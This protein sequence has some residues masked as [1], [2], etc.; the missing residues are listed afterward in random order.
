LKKPKLPADSAE[1]PLSLLKAPWL[2][3]YRY[4]GQ[5]V[6]RSLPYFQDLG[7]TMQRAALKISLQS[8][9]SMMLLLSGM[10][11]IVSFGII[12]SVLLII[13]VGV[14][15][16]VM[17]SFG[18]GLLLGV[19]V[20]SLLYFLP[21][22]LASTR[23]KKMDL[24]LPYVASHMSILAAAAIPPTRIFKLLEDSRT[25]P[26]VASDSNEIVRDVEILG[27]DIMTALETERD[28]SPSRVFGDMLEGLVATIRS[29][30]NMKNYLLDAT[31]TIMDLR[32][33]A[34]K[35]LIESLGVFAETYISLMIV[36][37]LLIIVMFSVMALIGGGLGGISVTMMMSLVT[38]GIIPV[39]GMAVIVMLDSILVED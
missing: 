37:P 38:Y 30:G 39:C 8:Y 27:K 15:L 18:I 23:R 35:Q 26:E 16:A 6:Q 2:L 22:L 25:T 34:A 7:I 5:R 14:G 28:R 11:T 13:K 24:E 19:A 21:S 12:T 17:Y 31:H 36:F 29:G 33:I 10:S 3:A 4:L 20:F 1:K 32:R 9:V